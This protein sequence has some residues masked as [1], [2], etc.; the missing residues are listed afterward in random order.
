MRRK[1]AIVILSTILVIFIVLFYFRHA[2]LRHAF[3][4]T[5]KEKTN[6]TVIFNI[7]D[8]TYNVFNSTVTFRNSDFTFSNVSVNKERS[9]D[10]SNFQFNELKI[11]NLSIFKLL[12]HHE[13]IANKLL[14]DNPSLWFKQNNNPQPFKEKPKEIITGLR[15]NPNLLGDLVIIIDE[16]EITHGKV[17]LTSLIEDK[18]HKKASVGFK[19][20]LKNINST[21]HSFFNEQSFMFARNHFFTF[22][23]FIY[24]QENGNRFEFDSLVFG[25]H[26]KDIKVS[27][28]KINFIDT[29]R[30]SYVSSIGTRLDELIFTGVN[31]IQENN[32]H[33][34]FIDSIF[35]VNADIDLKKNAYHRKDSP[36]NSK[37]RGNNVFSFLQSV[38]LSN[39]IIDNVNVVA[40][41][42]TNDS[43]ITINGFKFFV[44]DILID[45]SILI[46]KKPKYNAKSIKMGIE[47]LSFNNNDL[48][49]KL[50]LNNMNFI[51][52]DKLMSFSD[53]KFV[54][55]KEDEHSYNIQADSLKVIGVSLQDQLNSK[56][57]RVGVAVYHPAI[58]INVISIYNNDEKGS[59]P[60]INNI[61]IDEIDVVD[62]DVRISHLD[63]MNT[64]ISGLDIDW[65]S[66]NLIGPDQINTI[67][68][69]NIKLGFDKLSFYNYS[70]HFELKTGRANIT[71]TTFEI[72][73]FNSSLTDTGK[74]TGDFSSKKIKIIGADLHKA[75]SK[76]YIL[77][78]NI[79][80]INPYINLKLPKQG[81][82]IKAQSNNN[83]ALTLDI[84]QLDLFDG[85]INLD[86]I[87]SN[88]F[89]FKSYFG[90]NVNGVF[91]TDFSDHSWIHN[92]S[93]YLNFNNTQYSSEQYDLHCDE[94]IS[95]KQK[96]SL[97]IK[98]LKINENERSK[99]K[100]RLEIIDLKLPLLLMEGLEYQRIIE[101]QRPVVGLATIKDAYVNLK[102]DASIPQKK[103]KNSIIH[104]SINELPFEL[105]ELTILNANIKT[106][107]YNSKSTSNLFLNRVD[108]RY[109][110]DSAQNLFDD[111]VYFDVQDLR[112][113][114]S[115]SNSLIEF[116]GVEFQSSDNALKIRNIGVG[117]IY[118]DVNRNYMKLSFNELELNHMYLGH[119]FP[120]VM[121]VDKLL[122]NEIDAI[123]NTRETNNNHS[124]AKFPTA[125]NNVFINLLQVDSI[126][127]SHTNYID[128]LSN[129]FTLN[130]I[131]V[132]IDSINVDSTIISDVKVNQMASRLKIDMGDNT[133]MSKDSMYSQQIGSLS[134]DFKNNSIVMD[135]FSM[136]PRFNE[137]EFFKK[138]V[139]QTGRMDVRA[140]SIILSNFRLLKFIEKKE[141]HAGAIDVYGLVSEIY[142]NKQYEINP[143]AYKPM[144]QEALF[145]LPV[146]ITIDSVLTH[147]AYLKYK[148]LDKKSIVPGEIFLNKINLK[149]YNI[150]NNRNTLEDKS[151]MMTKFQALLLG[152]T[153]INLDAEFPLLSPN[154]EFSV[155][156]YL[157]KVY[158]HDLNSMTQNLVGVNMKSGYGSLDIPLIKGN[159]TYSE[160]KI[161][162]R[163]KNLK[164]DLYDREKA[165]NSKGLAGSMA[166][167]LLNDIFIR[168]NN[169][170]FLG[171]TRPGEV[172]YKRDTQKFIVSY[173]WK[174]IMSGLMSTMGYNN[175]E[176]RQERRAFKRASKTSN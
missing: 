68:T 16:L 160:G 40:S 166:N 52:K 58:D 49:T 145:N 97:L 44:K 99:R 29:S 42:I 88:S 11:S 164:I 140:S 79:E 144:P 103:L 162:F 121:G 62:G 20:L 94:L 151:V 74:I 36:D 4:I 50:S 18:N 38:N 22:S 65:D 134:Y 146:T 53:I 21:T 2:I 161:L 142:R 39:L 154:Y 150:S 92:I 85:R 101:G 19:L 24:E 158:F 152:K 135:S 82:P 45:S 10:L 93:W 83:Q 127:F 5:I 71:N 3:K 100:K 37:V 106:A 129:S 171:R 23:D 67:N 54:E 141:L 96:E 116:E 168:S 139:W 48:N 125:L 114:D 46:N 109:K 120:V 1:P 126:N 174:S 163:Y 123:I 105:D 172:Y 31:V 157:N 159:K 110:L 170:G 6:S 104:E 15:N 132:K 41:D 13:L 122:I 147:N 98:N 14:V 34:L 130:E 115:V 89:N 25:S 47:R 118:D 69:D 76:K 66:V 153:E 165:Q 32:I 175:K 7:G 133:F 107:K 148:E 17:D 57:A 90:I 108:L 56:L 27:N 77:A 95:D 156:G 87:G 143:K 70:N 59:K 136:I 75:I 12:F 167:L 60:T 72:N 111:L 30:S 91:I 26:S 137:D 131:S 155:S 81:S 176:Q 43:L 128:T 8:L 61:I 55:S 78:Q 33:D 113:S 117:N 169:P 112:F 51:E 149:T 28:L 173:M 63:K 84:K 35:L 64:Q 124:T 9:I 86:K 119:S 138:A 73:G 80:I 102:I